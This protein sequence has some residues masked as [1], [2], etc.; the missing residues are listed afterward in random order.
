MYN[1]IIWY[2]YI[3]WSDA[4]TD[5]IN[6]SVTLHIYPYLYFAENMLSSTLSK[7]QAYNTVLTTLDPQISF[8]S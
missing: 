6:I 8:T 1:V 2:M 3:L 5:F 7:F 4:S